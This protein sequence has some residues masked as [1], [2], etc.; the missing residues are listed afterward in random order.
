MIGGLQ[1]VYLFLQDGK[2][3]VKHWSTELQIPG[4][5]YQGL[6]FKC[7]TEEDPNAVPVY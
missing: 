6:A 2:G 5:H 4:Y 1:N 3:H 7:P